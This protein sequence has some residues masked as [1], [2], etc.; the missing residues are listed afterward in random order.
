MKCK[1]DLAAASREVTSSQQDRFQRAQRQ[2]PALHPTPAQALQLRH[3]PA[4]GAVLA[5]P[6]DAHMAHRDSRGGQCAWEGQTL[7]ALA[8]QLGLQCREERIYTLEYN[9]RTNLGLQQS[10]FTGAYYNGGS[11]IG[12]SL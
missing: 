7:K 5:S 4:L 3:C 10:G 8:A 11:E 6:Q 9:V 12:F 2:L 1:R